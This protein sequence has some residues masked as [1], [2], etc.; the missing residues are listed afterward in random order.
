MRRNFSELQ[1][2]ISNLDSQIKNGR[3]TQ[4]LE[5]CLGETKESLNKFTDSHF[6]WIKSQKDS[7]N[8][9]RGI[10]EEVLDHIKNSKSDIVP[11][12]INRDHIIHEHVSEGLNL[13]DS[14][15]FESVNNQM[16]RSITFEQSNISFESIQV[17]Q[18]SQTI[19]GPSV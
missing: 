10:L 5:N 8:E 3:N 6:E 1:K 15:Q 2:S 17:D 4:Q 16:Q 19:A 11:E 9:L 14:D 13:S 7:E 12:Y 18:R